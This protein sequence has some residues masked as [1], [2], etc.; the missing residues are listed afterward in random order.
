MERK[1]SKR[2][3]R[4]TAV[5]VLEPKTYNYIPEL[6]SKVFEKKE[7][8]GAHVSQQIGVSSED[9]VRIAPNISAVPPPSVQSLVKS[10]KSRFN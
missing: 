3:Q 4:W 8:S 10:H 5:K 7:S 9:P 2:T 1:F 6:I